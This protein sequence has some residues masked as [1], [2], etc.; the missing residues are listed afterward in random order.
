V[1]AL[2]A[3]GV[4]YL[5]EDVSGAP[6]LARVQAR[7]VEEQLIAENGKPDGMQGMA[8]REVIALIA[9]LQR[10]GTDL[11]KPVDVAPAAPMAMGVGP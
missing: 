3:V 1:Q 6:E 5:A 9:Y 2:R 7:K 10:L 11:D 8:S 4:P